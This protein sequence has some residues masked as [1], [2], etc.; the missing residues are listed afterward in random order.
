MLPLQ[1]V[2][3]RTSCDYEQTQINRLFAA[4]LNLCEV[5]ALITIIAAEIWAEGMG[6]IYLS[7][8]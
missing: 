8:F 6:H 3:T 7:F 2:R 4:L 1:L 5:C